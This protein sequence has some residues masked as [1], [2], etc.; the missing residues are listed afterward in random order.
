MIHG[1]AVTDIARHVYDEAITSSS[2][3]KFLNENQQTLIAGTVHTGSVIIAGEW[4][5]QL[6]GA[7]FTSA[8]DDTFR[9]Q[10]YTT[11]R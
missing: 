2:N 4:P 6:Q 11:P 8:T 5:K 7:N 10:Y 9:Q 1:G 3:D